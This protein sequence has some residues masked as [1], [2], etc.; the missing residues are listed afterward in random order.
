MALELA[1]CLGIA[2]IYLL[3]AC[4]HSMS[5]D[6]IRYGRHQQG[7]DVFAEEKIAEHHMLKAE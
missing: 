1:S 4:W 2:V 7:M 6:G 5:H 3:Y